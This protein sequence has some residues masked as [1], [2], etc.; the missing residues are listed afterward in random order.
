[1]A[2][3]DTLVSTELGEIHDWPVHL[4]CNEAGTTGGGDHAI[5]Q[6]ARVSWDGS[7]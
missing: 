2:V 4:G 5:V 1:M 3:V 6:L 7:H